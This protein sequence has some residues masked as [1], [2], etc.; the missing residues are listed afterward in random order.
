MVNKNLSQL[1]E[2]TDPQATDWLLLASGD[3]P[4]VFQKVAVGNL[5]GSS[6]GGGS[7]KFALPINENY[8]LTL[9]VPGAKS[10]TLK[11][12]G[13][14]TEKDNDILRIFDGKDTF[15][16]LMGT[17]SG[18]KGPGTITSKDSFITLHFISD[19][20]VACTGWEAVISTQIIPPVAPVVSM[21]QTAK[22]N[23]NF[24]IIQTNKAVPCDSFKVANASMTGPITIGPSSIVA[25]NCSGGTATR[26]RVN[27][28]AGLK[29]NG[30]YS[31]R[32]RN[33]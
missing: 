9:S 18:N 31:L 7:I 33:F 29:L 14:C 11:F 3:S 32:D 20:S 10:I 22:C 15:A 24:I 1:P 16:T 26:F 12:S 23:D 17:Y 5:P 25:Q 6:G 2:N 30:S 19:K 8:T 28:N 13:F 21:F 4:T 27:L